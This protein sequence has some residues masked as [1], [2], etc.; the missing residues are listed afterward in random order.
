MAVKP[1]EDD[2][3]MCYL[4]DIADDFSSDGQSAP[5]HSLPAL[6]VEAC[7]VQNRRCGAAPAR[8]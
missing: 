7:G 1:D 3:H 8:V 2:E 4:E 5:S 6:P